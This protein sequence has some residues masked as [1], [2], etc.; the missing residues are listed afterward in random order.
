MTD[1]Q[2]SRDLRAAIFVEGV[3][4]EEALD[5]L[6]E[7]RR[8]D[9]VSEGVLIVPM[10]GAHGIL[11]FIETYG[12]DGRDLQLG[13]LCDEGEEPYVRRAL[14]DAGLVSDRSRHAL[15]QAGFYVCEPDLEAELIRALGVESVARVIAAQGDLGAFRTLQREPAWRGRDSAEQQ[16]RFMGSGGGRKI[17]YG[18]LLVNALDLDKMP[19]PLE[20]V[21][22]GV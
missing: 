10:G 1:R 15:E 4:D 5:A 9:L 18:R 21:L 13:G 19:R 3:S 16:R 12:P 7:R 6:A 11:R 20:Q 22:A 8:R 2:A 17:R 14:F